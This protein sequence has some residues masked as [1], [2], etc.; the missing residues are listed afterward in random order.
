MNMRNND[1]FHTVPSLVFNGRT[2]KG[3]HH[4]SIL[5][6]LL[7]S[8]DL[9]SEDSSEL[10]APGCTDVL[11]N[12]TECDEQCSVKECDFDNNYCIKCSEG[13]SIANIGDGICDLGCVNSNCYYDDLD[14]CE[15]DQKL[16][17][18]GTC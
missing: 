10:C 2:I 9:C 1:Q 15:C 4:D 5:Y 12:N 11:L 16:I 18:D 14:C 3:Y 8:E 13:C 7:C 6:A 17:N